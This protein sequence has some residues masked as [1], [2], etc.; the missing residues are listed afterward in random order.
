MTAIPAH[1]AIPANSTAALRVD[2]LEVHGPDGLIVHGVSLSV[3]RGRTLAL[4]GESGSGKSL[5]ARAVTGLLPAGLRAEGRLTL[6]DGDALSL[7]GAAERDWR[8]RRG[9]RIGLLLQDPFTSLSPVHR[10]G[11]QIADTLRAHGRPSGRAEIAGR[12]AEVSLPAA[13]ARRFPHEMSGGML[14][15]AALAALLAADPEVLV[16]DE[17]TTALDASTQG[18]IIALIDRIRAERQMAVVLISHDLELVRG[19]A[20]TIEV[21][22]AGS[23]VERGTAAEVLERPRHPYTAELLAA[24]PRIGEHRERPT[25]DVT[26]SGEDAAEALLT[27]E[28]LTKS[29]GDR[30]VLDRVSLDIGRGEILGLVGESGS[31][32]TTLARCIVGLETWHGGRIVVDGR[33]KDPRARRRDAAVQIVFQSPAQALNPAHTVGTALAEVLRIAGRDRGEIGPLLEQVGLPAALA[34]RR[35]AELSG[36]Q[37]QRVAIARALALRP[38][39]LICDEPVSALDVSVQAQILDLLAGLR[40]DTGLSI[41]FIS[42]D[43]GVVHRIADGVVVLRGGTVV[44]QGPT[45]QVL[46]APQHPYTAALVAAAPHAQPSP[47]SPTAKERP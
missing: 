43:L 8:R 24:V 46:G 16:A 19:H 34:T 2:G 20:D 29:F 47:R 21:L 25:A 9:R 41:L 32:K 26:A 36:G 27:V 40:R 1:T 30:A 3:E 42:H 37:R 45:D 6:A 23:V 12:L 44:E 10:I 15:R 18:E 33:E 4:V 7:G 14:Q 22:R 11:V 28:A 17:P 35:P 38:Q 13:V 5:T 39:V 31:G